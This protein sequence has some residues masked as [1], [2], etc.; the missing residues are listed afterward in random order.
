MFSFLPF[1]F[2]NNKKK[3]V[4]REKYENKKKKMKRDNKV[5]KDDDDD[6]DDEEMNKK[7]KE[8][9][10]HAAASENLVKIF[11]KFDLLTGLLILVI[12]FLVTC[13][14]LSGIEY[15]KLNE[16]NTA[17][18]P[19]SSS[20]CIAKCTNDA[21]IPDL[22]LASGSTNYTKFCYDGGIQYSFIPPPS[23]VS[24]YD[25]SSISYNVALKVCKKS[26][27][28]TFNS[29]TPDIIPYK[30]SGCTVLND[31][32]TACSVIWTCTF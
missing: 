25:F 17:L 3:K 27:L 16:I 2:L 11:G 26:I 6:E 22:T 18:S 31:A 19:S 21:S 14:V 15:S 4:K 10:I 12:I 20:G 7:K 30:S 29:G 23:S 13:V 5:K 32:Y 24:L 9:D 1:F 28:T 8:K